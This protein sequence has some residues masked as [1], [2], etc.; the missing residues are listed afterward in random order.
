MGSW[1]SMP[2]HRLQLINFSP[3][4]GNKCCQGTTFH[5]SWTIF[6]VV[7]CIQNSCMNRSWLALQQ[8]LAASIGMEVL[9]AS[10]KRGGEQMSVLLSS[11]KRGG[12][13]DR[14][15]V[16]HCINFYGHMTSSSMVGYQ[17]DTLLSTAQTYLP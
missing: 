12:R 14:T 1:L 7:L 3:T 4:P 2:L 8:Y 16:T 6:L 11:M 13:Q 10:M 17:N 5:V 9:L 15:H